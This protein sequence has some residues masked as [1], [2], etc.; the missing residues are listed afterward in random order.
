MDGNRRRSI[1]RQPRAMSEEITD[2][3]V[4]EG[5][6]TAIVT[7]R[8]VSFHATKQVKEY[9]R[10]YGKII[11]GTPVREKA[12]D[13]MSSDGGAMT[14]RVASVDMDVSESS[15]STTTTPFKIFDTNRQD[16]DGSSM[17]MSLDKTLNNETARL[18]DITR[19]KTL[20]YEKTTEVTT[21]TTERILTVPGSGTDGGSGQD[22]TMAL[23]NQTDR[24]EVDM[25]VDQGG[26]NNETLNIFNTT[27]RD[28]TDMDITSDHRA[29]PQ[30]KTPR[31]PADAKKAPITDN[32]EPIDMDMDT[33]LN[34]AND[35]MA[36]FK[37][38]ARIK[39]NDSEPIDMDVTRDQINNETLAL[40]QTPENRKKP[41]SVLQ[42][43]PEIGSEAMDIS[44]AAGMTPKRAPAPVDMEMSS[45]DT[46]ALFK[47]TTPVTKKN[48]GG[49]EDMDITQRPASVADDTMA[50][51]KSPA[52]VETVP[53]VIQP[54]Q[55]L[56][57][58]SMEMEDQ[59]ALSEKVDEPEDVAISEVLEAPEAPEA[60]SNHNSMMMET[61]TSI[62]EEDRAAVQ[63]S[64]MDV[65]APL[66]DVMESVLLNQMDS[67]KTLTTTSTTEESPRPKSSVRDVTSSVHVSSVTLNVSTNRKENDSMIRTMQYTEVDTTNTFQNT[68][69]R[70]EDSDEEEIKEESTAKET[71]VVREESEDVTIQNQQE[72]QQEMS[73]SS[74]NLSVFNQTTNSTGSVPI[75]RR[76]RSLLREV[77]ESQR[78]H[79]MEKSMNISTAGGETALEEYRKEKMN[80]SGV[81]NQSL[82]QSAQGR[83]IFTMNT[84]IRSPNVRLAQGT[85]PP[86]SPRFEMPLYDPAV[87]NIVY[88]TPENVNNPT[89]LPEAVE[90]Q[91]VL[92]EES[93]R[94][95][96]EI[97]RKQKES[98]V[99]PE[100]LEW[101]QKNEMSKLT[102]DEREVVTIAREE[103]EIRFLRL[104]LKFAKEQREK[105]DE[106]IEKMT[107][108]NEK[109]ALKMQGVKNIPALREEV[110]HLR[111]Q[112]TLAECHRIEAEHHEMK[113]LMM[114]LSLD[115]IRFMIQKV[116]EQ[117]E[118]K[119]KIQ[120]DIEL[121]QERIYQLEEEE[122]KAM[123]EIKRRVEEMEIQW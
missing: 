91:K 55:Q 75:S 59:S 102:R 14:P 60:P 33:T 13:T 85:P 50:L 72:N 114:Q 83:D 100:K 81:M 78:R 8:R 54:Q 23:F 42:K 38:P 123:D 7:N 44:M 37:S 4:V 112:P 26:A 27:N 95:Q 30:F 94:V 105:G 43:T 51:F 58:E 16:M 47:I 97:Q 70:M 69:Q 73:I 1:L 109:L 29:A 115:W 93:Q 9:D 52:R 36:V 34:A 90:F 92:A 86:K 99:P 10:E 32:M 67:E 106:M 11:N 53:T 28:V 63:M 116:M 57:E 71:T 82:D 77:C 48:F 118:L 21:R 87:V 31:L 45:D 84:S 88:L 113:R 89:P 104:R 98:G 122:K 6:Q 121:Q 61:E 79:A 96:K 107:A 64:M 2:E 110:E 111:N 40:F 24:Q 117:K 15:T 18:F 22:D 3:N 74:Y 120:M 66:D 49:E 19:E 20:I 80:A 5:A 68:S 12:F 108:E 101:I 17:D 103:A 76:R 41:M 35:T 39:R 25:S 46:M 56:F 62:V 65:T 119:K